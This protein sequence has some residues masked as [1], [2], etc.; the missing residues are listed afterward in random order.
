MK[1]KN[2]N[3]FSFILLVCACLAMVLSSN[4]QSR[5]SSEFAYDSSPFIGKWEAHSGDN[6]FELRITKYRYIISESRDLYT[7][8][9]LG[10]MI[11]KKNGV[12]TRHIKLNNDPQRATL[13]V[14]PKGFLT[15]SQ[16]K[17]Y[18]SDGERKMSGEGEFTIDPQNPRK[19]IWELRVR[20]QP[21]GLAKPDWNKAG[22]D[23][24]TELEWTK[25]E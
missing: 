5:T 11:Y 2:K 6:S 21:G 22:F 4:A 18:Y 1:T 25:I 7:N 17:F 16:I 13:I 9:L 14:E 3:T 23:I 12:V 10:E 15:P 24:P 19:A 20:K 8:L